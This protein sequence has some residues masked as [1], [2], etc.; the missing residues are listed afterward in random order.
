[1]VKSV[2]PEDR[3]TDM[4]E[5]MAVAFKTNVERSITEQTSGTSGRYCSDITTQLQN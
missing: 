2:D 3:T 1:M 5:G 4:A